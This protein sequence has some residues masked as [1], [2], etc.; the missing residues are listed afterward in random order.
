[1]SCFD[2]QPLYLIIIL[3][4]T[5]LMADDDKSHF[6]C[7]FTICIKSSL[8][9]RQFTHFAHFLFVFFFF[10]L[11]SCEHLFCSLNTNLLLGMWFENIFYPSVACCFILFKGSFEEP[12]SFFSSQISMQKTQILVS[13]ESRKAWQY[14]VCSHA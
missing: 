10:F 9:K 14:W 8:V 11:L 5:S 2:K 12:V 4:C 3:N 1:M 13:F 6:I 7:S